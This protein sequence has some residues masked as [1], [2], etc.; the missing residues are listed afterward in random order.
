MKLKGSL[1]KEELNGLD[2][3]SQILIRKPTQKHIVIGVLTADT[4]IE[5][6]THEATAKLVRIEA[7]PPE[8]EAQ[9]ADLLE[10]IFEQRTGKTRLDMGI[11]DEFDLRNQF[12][13]KAAATKA[14]RQRK[15]ADLF[16]EPAEIGSTVTPGVQKDEEVVDA[17]IVDEAPNEGG[18]DNP[19][20]DPADDRSPEEIA[21]DE[22]SARDAEFDAAA[23]VTPV[24]DFE[25]TDEERAD[26][27]VD[28]ESL[29]KENG[30]EPEGRP[31]VKL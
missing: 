13:K 5:F 20:G 19:S 12:A 4:V 18:F 14:P 17:E 1:P 22:Q 25:P 7:V 21:A 6:P 11:P 3:I 29:T 28:P 2:E 10:K 26:A 24:S 15:D 31:D 27:D 16:K 30:T 9:F 23:P 8:M